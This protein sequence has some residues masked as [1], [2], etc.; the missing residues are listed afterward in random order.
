[1]AVL[2]V[3]LASVA[4][5]ASYTWVGSVSQEWSTPGNWAPPGVPGPGD[6]AS[7]ATGSVVVSAAVTVGELA[8]SGGT[9]GGGGHLMV[10]EKLEWSG[11]KVEVD[12][13]LAAGLMGR[14]DSGS[15]KSLSACE[16]R[17]A[18]RIEWRGSGGVYAASGAQWTNEVGGEFVIHSGDYAPA[19]SAVLKTRLAST[20]DFGRLK[21]DGRVTLAGGLMVDLADGYAPAEGTRF[22][23]LTGSSVA[24]TF[25][26]F[27][28][29]AIGTGSFMNPVYT[30]TGVALPAVGPAATLPGPVWRTED[31]AVHFEVAGVASQS[32]R[33]DVSVDLKSW[34]PQ[35]TFVMPASTIAE[36]VDPGAA[37]VPFRYY[38]VA[39]VPSP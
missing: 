6:A 11:G 24:G 19:E 1:M 38:R 13:Q 26:S 17:N 8:L 30:A 5:G 39:F 18:G 27:T 12:L 35:A 10:T 14:I 29:D 16:V 9:V 32:Y 4:W 37:A 15:I 2:L 3:G 7:I 33:V 25:D 31:G 20:T 21:V 34:Q 23:I 22:A 28:S 36:Y